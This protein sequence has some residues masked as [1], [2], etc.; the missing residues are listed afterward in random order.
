[1]DSR[2]ETLDQ[3]I[4]NRFIHYLNQFIANNVDEILIQAWLAND[5]KRI[6]Q[7]I[8]DYA[9]I[10]VDIVN[11]LAKKNLLSIDLVQLPMIDDATLCRVERKNSDFSKMLNEIQFLILKKNNIDMGRHH[12]YAGLQQILSDYH[13]T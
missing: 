5:I 13:L 7:H 3:E 1:M 6:S 2:H 10:E 9:Q 11:L 4:L 12:F 8:Y